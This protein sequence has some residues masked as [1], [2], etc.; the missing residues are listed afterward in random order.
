MV[1]LLWLATSIIAVLSTY[2]SAI[3][4]QVFIHTIVFHL[5]LPLSVAIIYHIQFWLYLL[6]CWSEERREQVLTMS[7]LAPTTRRPLQL[8][9]SPFPM[10]AGPLPLVWPMPSPPTESRQPL[11]QCLHRHQTLTTVPS[12]NIRFPKW[13]LIILQCH[14]VFSYH[15]LWMAIT[16]SYLFTYLAMDMCKAFIFSF[17]SSDLYFIFIWIYEYYCQKG[18]SC[19]HT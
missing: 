12:L 6:P 9:L 5:V 15:V 7:T 11:P 3:Q 16:S 17:H 10:G 13:L 2:F 1:L 8:V 18:I 19:C 4:L 14:F